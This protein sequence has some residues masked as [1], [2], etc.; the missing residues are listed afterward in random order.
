MCGING[1]VG[2]DRKLTQDE[3]GKIEIF[4]KALKHRGPD[5]EGKY[6]CDNVAF[7]HTRLAIIDIDPLANQPMQSAEGDI[8]ITFNG[9]IYNFAEIRK[10]LEHDYNFQTSHSDTEV[11]IYA[12]KKWGIK[13][14]DK[15]IGMFAFALHDH[16]KN[17]TYLC[18]DRLGKKPLYYCVSDG[19]MYFSS[20]IHAIFKANIIKKEI[21]DQA[22]YDYLSF[23]TTPAPATFYENIFKLEAGN[24]IEI[25]NKKM[26]IKSY[27]KVDDYL[28][29]APK[30]DEDESQELFERLLEESMRHR[31]ISDVPVAVAL[32]G[33]LDSSLNLYFG[34][35]FSSHNLAAVNLSYAHKSDNDESFIAKRYSDHL[36]IP[37]HAMEITQ[38]D[39]ADWV[40]EYLSV[41]SDTPIGDPNT[42]LLFGI[43]KYVRSKGYKVLQVGEGGDELGGYP[44]Y[45]RLETL[46]SISKY[47]PKIFL[48][49][50]SYIPLTKKMRREI[51]VL[52]T[53]GA[54]TRRFLFGYTDD[55]KSEFWRG[56][57]SV[58]GS[59]TQLKRFGSPI[60]CKTDDLF[61]RKVANIE[62]N[63]RLADLILPRVDYPTMAASIE[64]RSPFMD[65]RLIE[66]VS[67]LSF[68]QKM[69]N[70]SKYMIKILASRILPEYILK[71]PKVGFGML[72]NPFLK[73]DLNAWF[74]EEIINDELAPIRKYIDL[75]FLTTIFE[76][77]MKKGRDG[78]RLWILYSLNKWLI[79]NDQ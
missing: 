19:L 53:G 48:M 2:I 24:Y 78:Y 50:L 51:D 58:Q 41:Q 61:L 6:V 18:R 32:S 49:G 67:T 8:V 31:Y 62:Y 46:A 63:F 79:K 45:Q 28:N 5:A 54:V 68:R 59:F 17:T 9:E 73:N 44:I 29:Q 55:E 4:N 15:F 39:F 11:I 20:E 74:Q 35:K 33:G 27:W 14:L 26:N 38:E 43:S 12:Y 56:S 1:I 71:Q 36:D 65:H 25:R 77:N 57:S 70:G 52:K 64:A 76:S 7:G 13:C 47:I 3:H 10:E 34:K 69:K 21:N 30:I 60:T 75:N 40:K 22:V 23:L 37:L 42:P 16:T 66:E 72:L